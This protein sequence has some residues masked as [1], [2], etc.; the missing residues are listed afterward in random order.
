MVTALDAAEPLLR[1]PDQ[2]EVVGGEI[3]ELPPMS[4]YAREV[5][6]VLNAA[7][8]RHLLTH[9]TG[10]NRLE[11]LFKIPLP[12]DQTR[13]RQ[14]DAVYISYDRW[15]ANR[16]LPYTG[17]ALDVV[18]DLAVEVVS[19]GDSADDLLAKVR[20]YIRGGVRLVWVIYPLAREIHAYL[21]GTGPIRVYSVADQLDAPD[22]LPGF[23]A[24]VAALFPPTEPP[25]TTLSGEALPSS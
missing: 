11:L 5:A 22:I 9:D 13:N 4:F 2:Y 6:N 24:P 15:P 14:P 3:V 7:I 12:E 23:C 1:L 18:P 25:S 16:P 21:P 8:G 19:P 10:R 20:E 17:N